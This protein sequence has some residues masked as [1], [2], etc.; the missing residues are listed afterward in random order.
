MNFSITKKLSKLLSLILAVSMMAGLLAGCFGKD[1]EETDPS[2]EP[3]INIQLPEDT[4]PV[5]TQPQPTE[6]EPPV[7]NEKLATVLS[8]LS[9]RSSPSTDATVMGTLYAGDKIEVQRR[10]EVTG[11]EWAYIISPEAGWVCMDFV[12]M[13]FEPEKPV[14]ENTNTPGAQ[15]TTPPETKPQEPTT[16]T[17]NIKGV[18]TGNNLNIRSEASTTTGKIQGS[19][20]KGDVVTILE[21]KNGWGRTNKGW[22]KMDYVNTT[23]NT[24]TNNNTNTNTNNNTNTNTNVSGNGS[25]TVQFRGI[26][27]A[28]ELNIRARASQDADRLGSYK[29]GDRVELLEKDGNWGRTNKGWISLSYVYQD[30]ANT[31]DSVS[32]VVT[33]D[34]LRIRSGPGT[35][36]GVVGSYRDGDE[37]TILARFTYGKTTWGCT[38]KG[39]ISMDYV[40][41]DGSDNN[42]DTVADEKDDEVETGVITATGLRIRSGPGKEY[43]TV[44]SLE[45]GDKVTIQNQKKDEDGNTW[46]RIKEG[47]ISMAYVELD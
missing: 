39:W 8:Q 41:V 6:T 33:A 43:E 16:N 22:I 27:T 24:N 32:G 46:G 1:T 26:V 20:N 9:I 40:D 18:V 3:N 23:G 35:D 7:I 36:Y 21:V 37:I 42:D 5:E 31:N 14:E 13:D 45:K 12:E 47:W 30:G 19:Y 2:T 44:G 25:T 34:E 28:K 17:T 4:Q 10:E 38:K 29:Y 15:E 11:I